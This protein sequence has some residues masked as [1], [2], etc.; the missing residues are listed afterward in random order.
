MSRPFNYGG[1]AVLEGVMMRGQRHMAVAV[2]HPSGTIVVHSEPLTSRVY[3]SPMAR[4]PF[5]RGVVMLWEMLSLGMRALV[6]SANVAI[7]EAEDVGN[8][9]LRTGMPKGGIW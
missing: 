9:Q 1:Q 5:V 2:R 7:A 3:T 8:G 4:L 6:F